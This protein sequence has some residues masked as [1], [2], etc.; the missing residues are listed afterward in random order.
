MQTNPSVDAINSRLGCAGRI[1]LRSPD[2]RPVPERPGSRT[3]YRM[4]VQNGSVYAGILAAKGSADGGPIRF[5]ARFEDTMPV[6]ELPFDRSR[7]IARIRD[8]LEIERASSVV[9]SNQ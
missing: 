9:V 3:K 5:P 7:E 6:H 8:P 1:Y 4:C 2:G